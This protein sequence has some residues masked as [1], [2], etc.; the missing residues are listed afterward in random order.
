MTRNSLPPE[1]ALDG[2]TDGLEAPLERVLI[3][4]REE[5][6]GL[7]ANVALGG[8]YPSLSEIRLGSR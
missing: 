3:P 5:M 4:G 6:L 7:I 1:T 2:G 8:V